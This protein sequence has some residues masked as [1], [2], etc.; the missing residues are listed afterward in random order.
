MNITL[1]KY[2]VFDI[3]WDT[4]GDEELADTLPRE[5]VVEVDERIEDAAD[6]AI[7]AASDMSGFLIV[8]FLSK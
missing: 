4:D 3:A 2:R 1:V 7:N 6:E 8:V 5:I